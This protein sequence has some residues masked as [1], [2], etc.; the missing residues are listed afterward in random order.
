MRAARGVVDMQHTVRALQFEGLLHRAVFAGLVAGHVVVVRDAEALVAEVGPV[1]RRELAAVGGVGR[2]DAVTRVE[3]DHRLRLVLE[4]RDQ[5]LHLRQRP[6]RAGRSG[7]GRRG[8][9]DVD[10]GRGGVVR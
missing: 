6:Q 7:V 3:H 4:V 8:G 5:R 1:D 9:H 2:Q 10:G